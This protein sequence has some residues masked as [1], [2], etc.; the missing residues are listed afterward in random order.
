MLLLLFAGGIRRAPPPL[1]VEVT[2]P[3]ATIRRKRKKGEPDWG[4]IQDILRQREEALEEWRAKQREQDKPI[5]V[6]PEILV[7]LPQIDD[8]VARANLRTLLV[9]H[10]IKIAP[11]RM[12]I[13]EAAHELD[14]HAFLIERDDEE[15]LLLIH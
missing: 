6:E 11:P 15:I 2:W 8:S 7:E 12:V 4:L 14:D 1:L 13:P 5:S 3:G 9:K 10:D